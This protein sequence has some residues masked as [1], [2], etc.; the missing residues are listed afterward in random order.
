[1]IQKQVMLDNIVRPLCN[2]S[3]VE[4][5]TCDTKCNEDIDIEVFLKIVMEEILQGW[6]NCLK[7]STQTGWHQ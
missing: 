5:H 3:E 2:R 4:V 1:M 7:Q 6:L